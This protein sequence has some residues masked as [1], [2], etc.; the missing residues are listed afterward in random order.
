MKMSAESNKIKRQKN[1]ILI[2]VKNEIP[3]GIE[4]SK[5]FAVALVFQ[6]WHY[7]ELDPSGS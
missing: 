7:V 5:S 3:N 1:K 6:T 2:S 4:N